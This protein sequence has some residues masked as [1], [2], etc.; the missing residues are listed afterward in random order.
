MVSTRIF[1]SLSDGAFT[2]FPRLAK[3]FERFP[4][5]VEADG[6]ANNEIDETESREQNRQARENDRNITSTRV[7]IHVAR[8]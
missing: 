8:R 1:S 4:D 5:N 6:R 3:N 2:G 7:K